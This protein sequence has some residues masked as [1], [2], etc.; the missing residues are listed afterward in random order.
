MLICHPP[1]IA[2]SEI[3]PEAVYLA[4][5]RVLFGAAATAVAAWLPKPSWAAALPG[6]LPGDRLNTWREITTYNNFYEFSP[7]K[8]AVA[9]LAG[10]LPLHPWTVKISGEVEHEFEIGV[11]DLIRRFAQ[12]ER[13]FRLRCVEGWSMVVPWLGASLAPLLAL[14]RPTSRARYVRFVA[15]LDRKHMIGQRRD[16][17]PWPY[18]EALTIAEAMHPYTTLVTGLYGKPLPPQNGAP[19]RLVVPWKYGFKSIKSIV[20]I[21][22]VE[23]RPATTWNLVAPDD[24]GFFAN[25]DPSRALARG[26]HSRESRKRRTEP[27]NGYGDAVTGLY[28]GMDE[29]DRL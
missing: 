12:Q 8:E 4:R 9:T 16:S 29:A 17:L 5:R 7:D 15:L 19:V 22:L 6:L 21:D 26:S 25:V 24:Y 20:A 18:T 14:A 1:A 2:A 28:Q 11:D 3:T 27:F 10:E 23:T 13:I